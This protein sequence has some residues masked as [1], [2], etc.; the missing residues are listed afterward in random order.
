M[1][2][3]APSRTQHTAPQSASYARHAFSPSIQ[4]AGQPWLLREACPSAAAV[5]SNPGLLLAGQARRC[6]VYGACGI[7][8]AALPAYA[9]QQKRHSALLVAACT[10]WWRVTCTG[11]CMLMWWR[12]QLYMI[13]GFNIRDDE[14]IKKAISRSNI[15][16]NCVGSR[17]ETM[18]W[19]FEDVHVDFP[20][21]LARLAKEAGHVERLVHISDMA[22]APDHKSKRMRTKALGDEALL[23]EFPEATI[24]RCGQSPESAALRCA[25]RHACLHSTAGGRPASAQQASLRSALKP[26]RLPCLHMH[27]VLRDAQRSAILCLPARLHGA[28]C[29]PGPVAGIEDHFY[30]YLVYQM[31]LSLFAPVVEGGSNRIQPTYVLDVADAVVEALKTV[32]TKGKTYY[33][34]GPEVLT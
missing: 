12:M 11:A 3:H 22:A 26:C 27:Q 33:L 1:H 28:R 24:L 8:V 10:T 18:N 20:A 31:T 7:R 13:D 6:G 14:A 5:S 30:N 21:R 29:R 19:G 15:V 4:Y 23:K 9:C 17:L 16:V 25:Y 2:A 32:E 34:G